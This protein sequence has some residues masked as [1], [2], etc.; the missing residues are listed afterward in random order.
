MS[1]SPA[2]TE[3]ACNASVAAEREPHDYPYRCGSASVNVANAMSH[4][5]M[6]DKT[7]DFVTD[8]KVAEALRQLSR[9][10]DMLNTGVQS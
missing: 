8:W 7:G 6:M 5:R 10:L 9:A 2:R 1:R 3:A 4:L